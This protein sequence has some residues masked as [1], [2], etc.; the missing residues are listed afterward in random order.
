ML[1]EDELSNNE[2]IDSSLNEPSE[3]MLANISNNRILE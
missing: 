3:K 1:T 2:L